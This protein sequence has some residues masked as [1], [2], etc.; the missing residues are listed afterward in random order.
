M[1]VEL[2]PH[3]A[4]VSGQRAGAVEVAAEPMRWTVPS[5]TSWQSETESRSVQVQSAIV[6]QM[7][8]P[9]PAGTR[10]LKRVRGE[11]PARTQLDHGEAVV[12][13]AI[14]GPALHDRDHPEREVPTVVL[15]AVFFGGFCGR[16]APFTRS[17][18]V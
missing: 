13:P 15:P 11:I 3:N 16:Q 1:V 9:T 6:Q 2:A 14:P 8:R 5:V 7:A 4:P 18:A 10:T 17:C 12:Q